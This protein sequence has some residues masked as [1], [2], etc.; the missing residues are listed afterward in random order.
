MPWSSSRLSFGRFVNPFVNDIKRG[1]IDAILWRLGYYDEALLRSQPPRDFVYPA[2]ISAFDP[3]NPAAIW[4]GHSTFLVQVAGVTFLTDPIFSPYC[5]P[6]HLEVFKRRNELPMTID[7][8]PSIDCVLIS[9]NHY[10]HLD[11]ASVLQLHRKQ[12]DTIWVVPRGLK[13]WFEQRNISFVHELDWGESHRLNEQCRITAVPAQH[14]SGRHLWDKNRTLWCGY[15]VECNGKTFYFVGDTGYNEVDF[16]EVGIKWP[17]IDL[18]MI[19]IGV[20]VPRKFMQPVHISPDEAVKIHCDTG[21]CLSLGMHW[22]TFRLSE[23][24][25]NLPPYELYL[26]MKEKKLPFESFLPIDPGKFINW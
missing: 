24:P 15:V 26:A 8:L 1:L 16:K 3:S 14:F 9:H 20:Y 12:S 7:A 22:K 11:E 5:S 21:S 19:P 18:S 13:R 23:E 2:N 10:D 4:I 6:V 25:I 17:R